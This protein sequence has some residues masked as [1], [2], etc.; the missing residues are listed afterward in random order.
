MSN[1]INGY[2]NVV[3]SVFCSLS[4]VFSLVMVIMFFPNS[5][6]HLI[7]TFS[8]GIALGYVRNVFKTGSPRDTCSLPQSLLSSIICSLFIG[9][10]DIVVI[11]AIL[12]EG[13]TSNNKVLFGLTTVSLLLN[14]GTS[15]CCESYR[16]STVR[17]SEE[18]IELES[19]ASDEEQ[20]SDDIITIT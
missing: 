20:L 14:I 16:R 2:L 13:M 7:T 6:Q 3:T 17:I 11:T 1:T 8:S 12:I 10:L 5:F 15:I 9:V 4:S 19:R 18:Q